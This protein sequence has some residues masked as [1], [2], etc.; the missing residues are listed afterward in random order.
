MRNSPEYDPTT[1]TWHKSSHSQGG[2][3]CVE[4]TRDF[5][6]A[7]PVRDSKNPRGPK[8]AFRAAARAAFVEDLKDATA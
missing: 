1:A 7:V 5:A 3:D 4:V 2:S 6:A 8:H